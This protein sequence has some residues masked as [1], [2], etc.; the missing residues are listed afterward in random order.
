MKYKK[1]IILAIFLFLPVLSAYLFFEKNINEVCNNTNEEKV[2]NLYI[3]MGS[4]PNVI[5]DERPVRAG[6]CILGKVRLQGDGHHV[7]MVDDGRKFE[8][9]YTTKGMVSTRY[10]FDIEEDNISAEEGSRIFPYFDL[11]FRLLWQ[12]MAGLFNS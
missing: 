11:E 2:V 9:G 4:G 3:Q 5:F 8:F 7:L 12:W 1:S 10:Q 6:E